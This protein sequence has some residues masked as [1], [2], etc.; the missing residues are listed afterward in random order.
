MT[1]VLRQF[2]KPTRQIGLI[3]K[4]GRGGGSCSQ[5]VSGSWMAERVGMGRM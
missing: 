5:A 2:I 3:G 4:R 1:G